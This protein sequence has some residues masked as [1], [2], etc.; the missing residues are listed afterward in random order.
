MGSLRRVLLIMAMRAEA[1]PIISALSLEEVPAVAHMPFRWHRGP[2][3]SLEVMVAVNGMDP[4]HQVDSIATIPAALN[5]HAAATSFAPDLIISAGTA[6][7][8]S[9]NGAEIGQVFLNADRFVHHDRRID[10]PGFREYGIG[11]HPG[12]A[13]TGLAARLGYSIG[14]VTTSNSL[15]ETA[16]DRAEI[17]RS[18]AHVKEMEAA[19]VAYVAERMGIP[20]MSIKTITDLVDSPVDTGEQFME[21]LAL[22]SD[23]LRDAVVRVLLE[24]EDADLG[25][26]A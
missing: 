11:G 3:A 23:R 20:M 1:E 9:W 25:D 21:N 18:S 17:E 8:W 12:L 4:R 13:V 26:L 2:A 15:D 7:G 16:T 19:A 5:T 24:L 14:L 22:A 6:G 10:L